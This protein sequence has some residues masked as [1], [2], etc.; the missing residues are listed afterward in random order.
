MTVYVIRIETVAF[1][2]KLFNIG[3]SIKSTYN[4]EKIFYIHKNR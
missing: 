1:K 3:I 2:F 4:E